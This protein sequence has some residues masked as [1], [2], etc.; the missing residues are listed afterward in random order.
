M[1]LRLLLVG[2]HRLQQQL[3]LEPVH[4]GLVEVLIVVLHRRQRLLQGA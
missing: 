4:L 2:W 3:A 1:L